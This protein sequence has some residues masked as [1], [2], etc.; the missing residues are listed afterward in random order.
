MNRMLFNFRLFSKVLYSFLVLLLI[1]LIGT[2]GYILV[3]N[4]SIID[5]FYQTII[6]VSTVGFGEVKEFSNWGKLFTAFLIITSFGTFA[7][8]LT[9]ITGYI[10][11]GDYRLYFK[12]YKYMKK[13]NEMN[14]HVIVCGYGRVGSTAIE[15]LGEHSNNCL[16]IEKDDKVVE[17]F[18]QNSR[19]NC[20]KG[21]ATQDE[22]LLKSGIMNA[23]A[24]ITTLP[25]DSENL[26]VV[27]TA[28]ELNKNIKII[29]RA[30]KSSSVKKLKI[31]GADNVI[32]PDSLG[33][34]HMAQL[35]ATPDVLEFIDEISIEGENKI[36]LES[37]GFNEI[38]SDFQYKSI[39][40]LKK[41]FMV[42]NLIGFKDPSGSFVINPK[43]EIE[44]VPGCKILVLGTT[45]EIK[46]LNQIFGI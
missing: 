34:S 37:I 27:L 31:A 9:S 32:M 18:R 22:L 46:K 14:N 30:S 45:E 20:I 40:D 11:S 36:N 33:G 4:L 29:S 1:I 7:Y 42:C 6:T 13:I 26:F 2:I 44:I 38:P 5:A 21:D 24:L 25:S 15:T 10:V 19:F 35:V 17:Q 43:D 39:G 41:Q 8:A 28:R 23:K 12:E 3:E 16:L